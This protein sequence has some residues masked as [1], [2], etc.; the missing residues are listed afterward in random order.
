MREGLTKLESTD[1]SFLKRFLDTTKANLFFAKGIIL[2]EGWAEELFIPTLAKKI[3]YDLTEKG[4]SVVNVGNTSMLRYSK[5][6][7][8]KLEGA[9]IMSIPVSVVTD[10]DVK[11]TEK[12]TKS[13]KELIEAEI[14]NRARRIYEKYNGQTVQAFVSPYWT[15]EYCLAYSDVLAKIFFEAVKKASKEMNKD[16]KSIA[17]ITDEY[18]IFIND[19]PE[20]RAYRI[21]QEYVLDKKISKSII[22]QY[23]AEGLTIAKI[24]KE[25]ILKNKS[26]EYLVKAIKHACGNK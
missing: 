7:Q 14:E 17:V 10:V 25:E 11:P 9:T 1:Y 5:I 8:R 13:T 24:T 21:Y 12:N 23:F 16:G 19:S 18:E 26:V 6:F 15:L 22:A 3:D 2:V 4:V 20:H